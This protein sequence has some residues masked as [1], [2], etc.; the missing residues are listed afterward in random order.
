MYC[1]PLPQEY[2]ISSPFGYRGE[3][4][5]GAGTFHDGV[6]FACPQG[7]EVFAFQDGAVTISTQDQNGANW[8]DIQHGG[9]LKTRYLHLNNRLVKQG[10][11]IKK[12]QLI[13]LSGNTG[14]SSAP[15][16][17]FGTFVDGTA[18]DPQQFLTQS[19]IM[20]QK[21]TISA[22]EM[23]HAWR[24]NVDIYLRDR[25]L[26]LSQV[27][28]EIIN[29]SENLKFDIAGQLLGQMV[30]DLLADRNKQNAYIKQLEDEIKRKHD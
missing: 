13:G 19:S 24:A 7:T 14:L 12:G 22:E 27:R 3:P 30:V 16:L 6:D 5:A 23:L 20:N 11:L 18:V 2:P 28:P 15:H 26:D 10:D 9:A 1:Y 17:H 4:I 25:G 29:Q 21:P 8:I